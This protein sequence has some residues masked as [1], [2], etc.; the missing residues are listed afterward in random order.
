MVVLWHKPRFSSGPYGT[1]EMQR[2][3]DDLYA[4]GVDLLLCGH[5]HMY[6]RFAP[7]DP[8]GAVDTSLGVP[9]IT[10][11]TGGAEHHQITAVLPAARSVTTTRTGSSS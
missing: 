9:M 7:L 6:E 8:T 5:D 3:V 2:F 10:V 4:A 11:G 1:L